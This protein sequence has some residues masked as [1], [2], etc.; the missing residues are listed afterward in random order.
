MNNCSELKTSV[1][2]FSW[3]LC[4]GILSHHPHQEGL[5]QRQSKAGGGERS[6]AMVVFK[7]Q[8]YVLIN[9]V[10][11]F[12]LSSITNYHRFS[13]SN[14]KPLFL[15]VPESGKAEIKEPVDEC[16]MGA[17]FLVHRWQPSP[18]SSRA[19]ERQALPTLLLKAPI[20]FMRAPPMQPRYLSKTPTSRYCHIGD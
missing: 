16:L 18:V 17:C 12:I 4:Q 1:L 20:S 14:N 2:N 6:V 7:L 3:P 8:D 11:A 19:E 15:T 10:V 13:G 9:C 5:R